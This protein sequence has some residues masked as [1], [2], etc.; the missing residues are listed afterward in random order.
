MRMITRQWTE[1]PQDEGVQMSEVVAKISGYIDL[2]SIDGT[3]YDERIY[4][5]TIAP[6]DYTA[7]ITGSESR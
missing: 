4:D 3:L 5:D 6:E 7:T 2:Y 1:N